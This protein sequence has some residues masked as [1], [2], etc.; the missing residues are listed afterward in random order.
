MEKCSAIALQG[1]PLP[2]P[3]HKNNKIIKTEES[4]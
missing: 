2:A 1:K 3:N 4:E